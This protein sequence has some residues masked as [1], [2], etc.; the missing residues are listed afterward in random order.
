IQS[1]MPPPKAKRGRLS[2]EDTGVGREESEPTSTRRTRSRAAA[3][4]TEGVQEGPIGNEANTTLDAPESSSTRRITRASRGR[5]GTGGSPSTSARTRP[6]SARNTAGTQTD[7]PTGTSNAAAPTPPSSESTSSSRTRRVRRSSSLDSVMGSLSTPDLSVSPELGALHDLSWIDGPVGEVDVV[8]DPPRSRR[9]ATQRALESLAAQQPPRLVRPTRAA[10]VR[11]REATNREMAANRSSSV[12]AHDDLATIDEEM[13]H[14]L[15]DDIITPDFFG[16]LLHEARN[17]VPGAQPRTFR[18]QR[19]ASNGRL[20]PIRGG[21]RPA[22]MQRATSSIVS[23]DESGVEEASPSHS[24]TSVTTVR[25]DL[26]I[27]VLSSEVQPDLDRI[28]NEMDAEGGGVVHVG[29]RRVVEGVEQTTRVRLSDLTP[30]EV[31]RV[32]TRVIADA[33]DVM[34]LRPDSEGLGNAAADGEGA[35]PAAAVAPA[36]NVDEE[37]E[38]ARRRIVEL[39]AAI[40]EA[41]AARN[42]RALE[43]EGGAARVAPY[44]APIQ[45]RS[46]GVAGQGARAQ[47]DAER[48][49]R[50]MPPFL[51]RAQQRLISPRLVPGPP[52][53]IP[54]LYPSPQRIL[55]NI[56]R[57]IV[58]E[59]RALR[60][61][62]EAAAAAQPPDTQASDEPIDELNPPLPPPSDAIPFPPRLTFVD[63]P[64]VPSIDHFDRPITVPRLTTLT[65]YIGR[66]GPNGEERPRTGD[67]Y[68][69]RITSIVD[70]CCRTIEALNMDAAR[71]LRGGPPRQLNTAELFL[72]LLQAMV[73]NVDSVEAEH[74]HGNR[75]VYTFAMRPFPGMRNMFA[76]LDREGRGEPDQNEQR[77]RQ[78][79]DE[80]EAEES[81]FKSTEWGECR[82]CMSDEP[83]NPM[84][85]QFCRQLVGCKKCCNR[86]HRAGRHPNSSALDAI[87]STFRADRERFDRE[88]DERRAAM[89][90][91]RAPADISGTSRAAPPPERSISSTLR[92]SLMTDAWESNCPLCRKGWRGKPQVVPMQRCPPLG[93]DLAEEDRGDV[94]MEGEE[95]VQQ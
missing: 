9:A 12:G 6:F 2:V 59:L 88:H 58:R 52:P 19:D 10:A 64:A 84:G 33:E 43:R 38:T 32:V 85:C 23:G 47:I 68:D 55:S 69:R 66:T 53:G 15:L 76:E 86:W 30:E 22:L 94:P 27:D 20:I 7:E 14:N 4:A 11:A 95:G 82:I 1:Q 41:R 78:Q 46:E 40:Q 42:E 60:E 13:V 18:F 35:E 28:L 92:N 91:G 50:L 51:Q 56:R 90:D 77:L 70:A 61:Q 8:A 57:R 63:F 21:N 29:R 73:E 17:E 72:A 71:I 62:R 16:Q 48:R 54:P 37:M 80:E 25:L 26:Q 65:R 81:T 87:F 5:R 36:A 34:Q 67:D 39:Q 93:V 49:A 74:G 31:Q 24:G 45:R 3:A 89:R 75:R 44:R 83:S 79:E